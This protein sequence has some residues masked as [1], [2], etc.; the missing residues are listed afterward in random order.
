M[1]RNEEIAENFA[2]WREKLPGVTIC[3][4]TKTMPAEDVNAALAAGAADIGENRVQELLEKLDKLI[5]PKTVHLIGRLQTN[6]VKYLPGKV[7]LIQSL[8]REELAR[9]I[10]RR[11]TAAG[12]TAQ[13][14]I[15]VSVAGEEQKGGVTEE[16]L[17]ELIDL[18][19][20]L[21]GLEI[22]G[23]MSVMPLTERPEEL[24]PYFKK[25]RGLFEEVG[26]RD[27]PGVKMEILSMGM[28]GDC[29]VA[30]D[31]GATMV[32]IGRGIFGNRPV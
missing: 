14:L 15:Q 10:S 31:E 22:K 18:C 19:S 25:V 23:L 1:N 6:K 9:E 5:S 27:L 29:L 30:A 7:D 16:H 12:L 28:S 26:R 11:Y 24:R 32:R 17:D 8:D 4:V 13:A 21:P 3:A 20:R 2:R